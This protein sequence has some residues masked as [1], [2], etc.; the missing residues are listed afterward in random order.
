M[1]INPF[2]TL[3]TDRLILRK[4]TKADENEIL[5]LHSEPSINKYSDRPPA[6]NL[7]DVEEILKIIDFGIKMGISI[8]WNITLKDNTFIED[9]IEVD[10]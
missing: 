1:N 7:K 5:I 10:D 4:A 6:K 3:T 8:N 9:N 2:P